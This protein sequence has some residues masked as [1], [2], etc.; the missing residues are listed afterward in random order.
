MPRRAQGEARLT[1]EEREVVLTCSDADS[2]WHVYS[3]SRRFGGKL[4]KLAARWG[5]KVHPVGQGFEVE[6]PLRAIRL[7]GGPRAPRD[8]RPESKNR[9]TDPSRS[10]PT[11]LRGPRAD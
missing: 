4:R 5:A 11:A 7:G 3:D 9:P 2:V 8:S 6:L 1:R 10:G